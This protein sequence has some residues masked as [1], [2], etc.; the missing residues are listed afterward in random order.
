M[1]N[2][3]IFTAISAFIPIKWVALGVALIP[4]IGRCYDSLRNGGGL[5]GMWRALYLGR[6]VD[7]AVQV[8]KDQAPVKPTETPKP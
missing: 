7:T 5:R 2:T 3:D 6:S 1:N 8:A 4:V